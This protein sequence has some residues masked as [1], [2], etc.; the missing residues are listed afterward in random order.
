MKVEKNGRTLTL[1]PASSEERYLAQVLGQLFQ[2]EEGAVTS[3]GEKGKRGKLSPI[4]V[5]FKSSGDARRAA[6]AIET[7]EI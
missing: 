7:K 2:L 6:R 4:I 1:R 3:E 5:T